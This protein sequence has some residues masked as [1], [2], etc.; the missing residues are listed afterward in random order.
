MEVEIDV[1]EVKVFL[2]DIIYQITDCFITIQILFKMYHNYTDFRY[3][4]TVAAYKEKMI[5]EYDVKCL[6][7][8]VGEGST[9]LPGISAIELLTDYGLHKVYNW[10]KYEVFE[11]I[12][13]E[14][15]K[16]ENAVY[17]LLFL[18]L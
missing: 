15:D 18:P 8:R 10:F 17:R 2:L 7:L 9:I 4:F 6:Y 14:L 12:E 11:N 5:R 13:D 16:E 1:P 3:K